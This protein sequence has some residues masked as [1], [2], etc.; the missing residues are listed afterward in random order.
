M[1]MS[2]SA[3]RGVPRPTY[4]PV[5][6]HRAVERPVKSLR[7]IARDMARCGEMWGDVERYGEIWG[8]MGSLGRV[9]TYY[10]LYAPLLATAAYM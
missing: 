9:H 6:A 4:L 10:G 3:T 8:D 2:E 7:E 1:R 5:V